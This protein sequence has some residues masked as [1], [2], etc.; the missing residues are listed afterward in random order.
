MRGAI[1]RARWASLT[2]RA[3]VAFKALA[4]AVVAD[5][6]TRAQLAWRGRAAPAA[7]AHAYDGERLRL[8]GQSR[9]R[10]KDALR[11]RRRREAA[12]GEEWRAATGQWRR[13]EQ[14]A[15]SAHESGEAR[16]RAGGDVDGH[17]P[18]RSAA[19][20]EVDDRSRRVER[21]RGHW[22]VLS[23]KRQRAED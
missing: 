14:M 6:A 1:P 21:A 22:S 11:Q 18:P 13:R 23:P 12:R 2:P 9:E 5:A 3:R 10:R 4:A 19:E 8:L 16:H 17:N 7:I 20:A 15:G